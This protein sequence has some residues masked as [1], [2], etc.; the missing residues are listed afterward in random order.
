MGDHESSSSTDNQG[1]TFW[2]IHHDMTRPAGWG[3][4]KDTDGP[5]HEG[6]IGQNIVPTQPSPS[7]GELGLGEGAGSGCIK[8][9]TR[10]AQNGQG[11]QTLDWA[12]ASSSV[13][14]ETG[15]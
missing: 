11:G 7:V 1:V 8:W 6:S 13:R 5:L 14:A 9:G 10:F 15:P 3:S 4:P 12:N 2:V